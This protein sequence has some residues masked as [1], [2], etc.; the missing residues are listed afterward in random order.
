MPIKQEEIVKLLLDIRFGGSKNEF[1]EFYGDTVSY[2]EIEQESYQDLKMMV[3]GEVGKV[4]FRK[5]RDI[6]GSYSLTCKLEM[7]QEQY[8]I[9]TSIIEGKEVN[10]KKT[11][12][13]IENP[14]GDIIYKRF[15]F[16]HDFIIT[17]IRFQTEE[18]LSGDLFKDAYQKNKKT[19]F[20]IISLDEYGLD[21][22]DVVSDDNEEDHE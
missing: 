20:E 16:L 9:F 10:L 18:E 1:E 21:V 4:K 6:S 11:N 14:E 12:D 15:K 22:E 8:V 13:F 17:N 7:N 2:Q 5:A 19:D 3:E